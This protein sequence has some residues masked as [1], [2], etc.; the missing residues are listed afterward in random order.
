MW[1][2]DSEANWIW[3][4]DPQIDYKKIRKVSFVKAKEKI[5]V[6]NLRTRKFRAIEN[7]HFSDPI[8][9]LENFPA[10]SDRNL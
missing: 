3:Y 5:Y 10:G 2:S 1:K 4:N 8:I 7:F 6:E 9:E